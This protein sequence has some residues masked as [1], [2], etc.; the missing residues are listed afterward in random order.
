LRGGTGDLGWLLSEPP[1]AGL[2]VELGRAVEEDR[3]D[4]L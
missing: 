1:I 3:A 2:D 4:R